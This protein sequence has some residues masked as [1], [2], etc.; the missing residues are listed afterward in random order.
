MDLTFFQFHTQ[1]RIENNTNNNDYK[2][3]FMII[4][5]QIRSYL[6]DRFSLCHLAFFVVVVNIVAVDTV[7]KPLV[8]VLFIN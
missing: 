8:V 4:E 5:L 3:I 2:I 7:D 1:N 6:V